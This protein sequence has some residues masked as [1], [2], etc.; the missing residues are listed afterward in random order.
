MNCRAVVHL[1]CAFQLLLVRP[2][3]GSSDII[4]VATDDAGAVRVRCIDA[5][6]QVTVEGK[7]SALVIW[8][9][10]SR[11]RWAVVSGEWSA[12]TR[13]AP[14]GGTLVA[15]PSSRSAS[16]SFATADLGLLLRPPTPY[17]PPPVFRGW[18]LLAPPDQARLLNPRPTFRRSAY[19]DSASL[20]ATQVV[21]KG[22]SGEARIP[23][24]EKASRVRWD[25]LTELPD[26]WKKGLPPGKYSLRADTDLGP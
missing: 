4:V 25:Q 22:E 16:A 26:A 17:F 7:S 19:G 13:V 9:E 15:N 14:L 3:C 18:R 21:L 20:R 1:A 12:P 11:D 8:A 23:F 24:A 2:L 6:R 5:A 10:A